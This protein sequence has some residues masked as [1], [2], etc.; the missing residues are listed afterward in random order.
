MP[1]RETA[2]GV[3]R[4]GRVAVVVHCAQ[5]LLDLLLV[6]L[7]S[8]FAQ[9]HRQL[10]RIERVGFV[11]VRLLERHGE[12]HAVGVDGASHPP[13]Q[14]PQLPRRELGFLLALRL[15]FQIRRD[16]Q[17]LP[18]RLEVNEAEVDRAR[19]QDQPKE[20]NKC[21]LLCVTCWRENPS[22]VL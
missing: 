16:A 6:D 1:D 17:G 10:L 8:E 3:Y 18:P 22:E 9:D 19:D 5:Q 13:L 15:I 2:V 11:S 20:D 21:G 7:H 14:L 12:L 4:C